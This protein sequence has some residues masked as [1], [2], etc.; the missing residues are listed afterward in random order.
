LENSTTAQTFLLDIQKDIL[1]ILK[2][3]EV[4]SHVEIYS[5]T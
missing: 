5:K 4:E 3:T 2:D 1:E